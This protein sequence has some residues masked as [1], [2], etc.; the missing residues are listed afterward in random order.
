MILQHKVPDDFVLSTGKNY[1]I[2]DFL[3]KVFKILNLNWRDF[4]TT[5]NKN[6]LRPS[7]VRNLKGDSKK[8]RKILKWKPKYNLDYLCKDMLESDLNLYGM[9]SKKQK[10]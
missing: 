7:E 3:E 9:T 4:V 2:K 8:A 1:S 6:F 10:K 5:N